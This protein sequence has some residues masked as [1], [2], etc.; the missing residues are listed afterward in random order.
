MTEAQKRR[1]DAYLDAV[2]SHGLELRRAGWPVELNVDA[3]D[4]HITVSLIVDIDDT[5]V[6]VENRQAFL[7]GI[8]R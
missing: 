1:L 2:R 5:R 3:T 8:A 6:S 4:G 7:E